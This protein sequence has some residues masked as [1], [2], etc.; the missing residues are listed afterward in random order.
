[1]SDSSSTA[2]VNTRSDGTTSHGFQTEARQ[3]LRLMIHSLYSNREIF[4]RELI[5]NASDAIDKLRFRALED[6]SLVGEDTDYAITIQADKSAGTL[7]IIDNGIGLS[8]EEAMAHLGT[9]A[10]SGTREFMSRLTG[11]QKSDA[12]LIGQFGVGF[13]PGFIV[14][15]RITVESRRAGLKPEQA[16]RWSSIGT[17]DFEVEDMTQAARGARV[18]LH[19]KDDAGDYLQAWKLKGIIAK[20]SDHISLPILMP[21]EKWQ[22]GQ[23]DQPGQMVATGQWETVNKASALW[24]RPKKDITQDQYDEFYKQLSY[25]HEAPLAT[26]HNRVPIYI[27]FHNSSAHG[28]LFFFP[29]LFAMSIKSNS[30]KTKTHWQK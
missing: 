5:S 11:D 12:Q 25:D 24:S 19:L 10:K 23:N 14:A 7:S 28:T 6:P 9:I 21:E 22:D 27:C 16:V 13:Y 1:M 2:D 4:L 3:L 29:L 15:D 30:S 17:G 26:T 20:Y 8:R 18:I